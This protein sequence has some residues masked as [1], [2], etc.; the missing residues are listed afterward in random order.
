MARVNV[1]SDT[2]Q[3]FNGVTYYL[4][5]NYYQ[6]KGKRLHRAVWEAYNGEIPEGYHIHHIDEDRHNNQIENLA[7]MPGLDHMRHHAQEESRRENGKK[8]I[9]LAV[10]RAPAW[11]R[12]EAGA[13]WH[14]EHAKAY[15]ANAPQNT[16]IC[17]L[18]GKE[19]KSTAVRHT[20]HHFCGQNCRA[21]FGRWHRSWLI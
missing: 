21:K 13:A 18:C 14:S 4:C 16:Y 20:G 1:L 12:S 9:I 2:Q 5:G 17:D 15:W 6:H 11:H 7:L 8:A 19:Y 10:Q 3:E